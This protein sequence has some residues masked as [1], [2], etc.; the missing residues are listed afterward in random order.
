M[1]KHKNLVLYILLV[2]LGI[3]AIYSHMKISDLESLLQ[4]TRNYLENSDNALR[5]NINNIYDNV[6]EQ[7]KKEA[8]YLSHV[9]MKEGTIDTSTHTVKVDLKVI[10]KE[11]NSQTKLTLQYKNQTYLFERNGDVYTTSFPCDLFDSYDN[12]EYAYVKIENNGLTKIEK[13]EDLDLYALYARDLPYFVVSNFT[14]CE[15]SKNKTIVHLDASIH[16]PGIF[17]GYD[18]TFKEFYLVTVIDGKMSKEYMTTTFKEANTYND[19]IV[20]FTKKVELDVSENDQVSIYIEAVDSL[21]Y[22]HQ[23]V[24]YENSDEFDASGDDYEFIL[25]KN[26]ELLM[27]R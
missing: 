16:M 14:E 27:K 26:G 17:E 8:S 3:N 21:G 5:N 20:H 23:H 15:Y 7:M 12:R 22:I 1:K 2:V 9:E 18:A 6:N 13:L 19:G 24:M 4:N 25:D 11:L 10:P